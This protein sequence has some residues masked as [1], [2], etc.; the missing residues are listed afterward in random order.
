MVG[1]V[2]R[3]IP[4]YDAWSNEGGGRAIEE[5]IRYSERAALDEHV[6]HAIQV[7]ERANQREVAYMAELK[8]IRDSFTERYGAD[9]LTNKDALLRRGPDDS[10]TLSEE[11]AA[12]LADLAKLER[13]SVQIERSLYWNDR[14][15][16]GYQTIAEGMPAWFESRQ[17]AYDARFLRDDNARADAYERAQAAGQRLE[18]LGARSA[19]WHA[20]SARRAGEIAAAT[21]SSTALFASTKLFDFQ[22]DG[23]VRI[24]AQALANLGPAEAATSELARLI[25]TLAER[26]G[27]SQLRDALIGAINGQNRRIAE[28]VDRA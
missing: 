20:Q 1:S 15:R 14:I 22:R 7:V 9:A 28:L 11:G 18:Y 3:H 27:L 25:G 13:E 10:V 17:A 4:I 5:G 26:N 24:D 2:G 8:A 6:P 21:A 16:H 19:E 12:M 23:T